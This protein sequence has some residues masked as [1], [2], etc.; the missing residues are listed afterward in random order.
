ML[1]S[2]PLTTMIGSGFDINCLPANRPLSRL[3]DHHWVPTRQSRDGCID[4]HAS[5]HEIDSCTMPLHGQRTIADGLCSD[6]DFKRREEA[7]AHWAY[8]WDPALGTE[9]SCS[10]VCY[11]R[12]RLG[13]A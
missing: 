4:P 6:R 9:S 7:S 11:C 10:K 13:R 2:A 12:V 1:S 8:K 3:D 5:P